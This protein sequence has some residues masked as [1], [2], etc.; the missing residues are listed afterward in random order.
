MNALTNLSPELIPITALLVAIVW[1]I[2]AAAI[3]ISRANL[4]HETM[5]HLASSG[6]PIPPELLAKIVDNKS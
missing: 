4:L 2:A 1:I 6:Q 5:R 3:K